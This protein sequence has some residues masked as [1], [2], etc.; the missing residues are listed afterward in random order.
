MLVR[1]IRLIHTCAILACFMVI[2]QTQNYLCGNNKIVIKADFI[3]SNVFD[4]YMC[5]CCGSFYEC[6]LIYL[7]FVK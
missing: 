1:T 5:E 4:A 7:F 6:L 3:I 2:P